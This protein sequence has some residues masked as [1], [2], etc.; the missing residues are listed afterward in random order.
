VNDYDIFFVVS[1]DDS[2][3]YRPVG[4]ELARE[5]NVRWVDIIPIKF[6]SIAT[7]PPSQFHY[8]LKY[9]SRHLWGE[10]VL[11]RIPTYPE[12]RVDGESINTLLLNRLVCALE[13]YSEEF[14]RR[15]LTPQEAF[16]LIN[17]TGKVVSAC[18]ECLLMKDGQYHPSYRTRHER[19]QRIFSSEFSLV[20][21][22]ET[23]T[24]F[25][26]RPSR[27]LVTDPVI[28]WKN[29]IKEYVRLLASFLVADSS[30]SIP[31]LVEAVLHKRTTANPI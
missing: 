22:N 24:Q 19:F 7:L 20:Q 28:Y 26:L 3:D 1:Y 18:V 12:G 29:A 4:T 15:P 25:K 11:D 27:S 10:Y 13:A 31:A 5:L 6:S 17:Q 14:E 23:A 16:F 8:D 21:L 30:P 2:T 9:G